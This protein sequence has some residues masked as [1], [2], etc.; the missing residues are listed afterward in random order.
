MTDELVIVGLEQLAV[1]G[2]RL[3]LAGNV[4]LRRELLHGLRAAAKPMVQEAHQAARDQLPKR[5][6][7]NERVARAPILVRNRLSGGPQVG[8][9]LVTTATDTRTTNEGRWRHPVFGHRDRWVD[10]SYGPAQGWFSETLARA[11]PEARK[12]ILAA[13]EKTALEVTRRI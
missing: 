11:A 13:I 6:G 2:A 12:Q 10:Q 5:G 4:T 3:Q 9:R 7:L 8:V 1:I